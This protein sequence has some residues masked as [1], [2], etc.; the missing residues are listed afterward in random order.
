M[1]LITTIFNLCVFSAAFMPFVLIVAVA[2][3]IIRCLGG[4]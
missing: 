2:I 3:V 4:A 1:K